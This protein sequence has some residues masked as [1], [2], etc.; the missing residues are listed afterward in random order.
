[1]Q[2]WVFTNLQTDEELE[3]DADGFDEACNI[4]FSGEH[5]LEP[6]D[7]ELTDQY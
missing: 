3:V 5:A 6:N 7:W 4:M 2:T 1:M